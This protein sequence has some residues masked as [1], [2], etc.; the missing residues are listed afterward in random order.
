MLQSKK[1]LFSN[2][3]QNLSS[4]EMRIN[5]TFG[6]QLAYIYGFGFI[7]VLMFSHSYLFHL[8]VKNSILCISHNNKKL[9]LL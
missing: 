1:T 8:K 2:L 4:F 3:T 9:K 6:K 7:T 5:L